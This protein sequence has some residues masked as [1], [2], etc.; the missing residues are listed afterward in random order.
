MNLNKNPKP[1]HFFVPYMQ[2]ESHVL[3]KTRYII[4]P[5]SAAGNGGFQFKMLW[6]CCWSPHL[7]TEVQCKGFWKEPNYIY[8]MK[9]KPTTAANL[10]EDVDGA[11]A[12]HWQR[13]DHSSLLQGSPLLAFLS[14]PFSLVLQITIIIVRTL[15]VM[16]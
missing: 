15:S 2:I 16:E 8:F 9:Y 11:A 3:F 14:F 1:L 7:D 4:A 5:K 13:K 10:F 6:S 12:F